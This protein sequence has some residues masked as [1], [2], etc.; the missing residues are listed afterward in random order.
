MSASAFI[1]FM[2]SSSAARS[3]ASTSFFLLFLLSFLL[4]AGEASGFFAAGGGW[5]GGAVVAALASAD[6][7]TG[8]GVEVYFFF[9]D[10]GA[11]DGTAVVASAS[12]AA[13]SF[14]AAGVVGVTTVTSGAAEDFGEGSSPA[15]FPPPGNSLVAAPP[16]ADDGASSTLAVGADAIRCRST[17]SW[18]R[19]WDCWYLYSGPSSV[20]ATCDV[21]HHNRQLMKE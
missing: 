6:F 17:A 16:P 18:T 19:F 4:L 2:N 15:S 14:D 3:S 8:F 1:S 11:F 13:V 21:C 5:A 12:V 7:A 9:S 20:R 10:P